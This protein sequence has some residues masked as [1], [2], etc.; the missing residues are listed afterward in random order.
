MGESL[1]LR[2]TFTSQNTKGDS[3]ESAVDG[4]STD[5]YSLAVILLTYCVAK[6]VINP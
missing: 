3:Q 4:V 5:F 2:E 6:W 1:T